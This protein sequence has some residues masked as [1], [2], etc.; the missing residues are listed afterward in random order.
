MA[1][2]ASSPAPAP[3]KRRRLR[4]PL[5]LATLGA[6]GFL[7]LAQAT[8]L[9]LRNESSLGAGIALG[10]SRLG[11]MAALLTMLLLMPVAWL[12]RRRLG[13]ERA[14]DRLQASWSVCFALAAGLAAWAVVNL[15][16]DGFV[17]RTMTPWVALVVAVP[18]AFAASFLRLPRRWLL[19]WCWASVVIV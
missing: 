3:T 7:G 12:L 8:V 1:Q 13:D 15:T 5:L 2:P 6:A 14:A 9:I 4:L 11:F 19:A 10:F 18:I 17:D 16:V